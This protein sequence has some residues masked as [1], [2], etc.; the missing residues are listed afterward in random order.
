MDSAAKRHTSATMP[1]SPVSPPSFPSLHVSDLELPSLSYG[2]PNN[3][4]TVNCRRSGCRNDLLQNAIESSVT[5]GSRLQDVWFQASASSPILRNTGY[6]K[7]TQEVEVSNLNAKTREIYHAED[8]VRDLMTG[9]NHL[10]F[11]VEEDRRAHGTR[12]RGTS[13]SCSSAPSPQGH[14][15]LLNEHARRH[16]E[17]IP[18][19]AFD[20]R[21]RKNESFSSVSM[22]CPSNMHLGDGAQRKSRGY[23]AEGEASDGNN[24]HSQEA[25]EL[26]FRQD[27]ECFRNPGQNQ[28]LYDPPYPDH[29]RGL[30]RRFSRSETFADSILM[31]NH[32]HHAEDNH[33]MGHNATP[34]MNIPGNECC[35]MRMQRAEMLR[36][37]GRFFP[38]H[39]YMCFRYQKPRAHF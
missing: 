27:G 25:S 39:E 17:D 6:K 35:G 8:F 29:Y 21:S 26:F 37:T 28:S 20:Q 7:L 33:G 5:P 9:L 13:P 24:L 3:I 14:R 1:S 18:E 15:F 2:G 32:R 19:I 38:F 4:V 30:G 12:V 36:Q 31:H 34:P 10:T 23:G 16:M 22:S 11:V